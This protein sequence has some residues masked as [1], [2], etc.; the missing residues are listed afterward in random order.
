GVGTFLGSYCLSD[1]ARNVVHT[2]RTTVFNHMLHLP[3]R[4]FDENSPGHLITRVPYH[5]EQLTGA[6]TQALTIS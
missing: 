5:V 4:Y 6:A 3:G 2:L 1:V